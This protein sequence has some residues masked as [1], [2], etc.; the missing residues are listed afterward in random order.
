MLAPVSRLRLVGMKAFGVLVVAT[1]A[2]LA[3]AVVGVLA[4]LLVVGTADGQLVTLSGSTIGWTAALARVGLVV[5]WTVGQLA[6]VGAVA[7]AISACH[8][9]PAGGAGRGARRADRVRG[10][11]ARSRRWSGCSPTCSP[12]AGGPGRTRCATRCPTDGLVEPAPCG[13]AATCCWAAG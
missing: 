3:I 4:G 6:A 13:P 1:L 2:T 11:R 12:P 10:A 5:V 7:L 9:A 8:R